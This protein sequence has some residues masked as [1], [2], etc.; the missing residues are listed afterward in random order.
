MLS[1]V[2]DRVDGDSELLPG[3]LV[4]RLILQDINEKLH[5]EGKRPATAAP[6]CSE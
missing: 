6:C 2:A 3:E 1:K 5:K 4:D